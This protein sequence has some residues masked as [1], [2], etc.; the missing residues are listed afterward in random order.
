METKLFHWLGR[1][2][3]EIRAEGRAGVAADAAIE[4]LFRRFDDEL[5]MYDLSLDNA[6]RVRV[7]GRDKGART[8][9]TAARAKILTGTK[10]VASSS[11]ISPQWFDSDGVAGLELLAMKPFT[12]RVDRRQVE[13]QP[14]RNYLCYLRDDSL[15]FFSGFTSEALTLEE[16]VPEIVQTLANGFAVS[17]SS[18]SKAMK[19][20]IFL[21]R[22][23]KQERLMEILSN[24]PQL[25]IPEIEV[26]CVDG[27]AGDKYWVEIEATA[28]GG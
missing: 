15:L 2:F 10:K 9:A 26:S 4:D 12:G 16:Q 14:V 17:G 5:R 3:V 13:F 22:S 19:L 28:L 24:G 25:T 21:H 11:F 7:W 23:Q 6:V 18:W 1:E 27:F 8:L 20:S